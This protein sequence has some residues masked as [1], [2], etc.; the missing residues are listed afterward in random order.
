ML[1]LACV[2]YEHDRDTAS[3]ADGMPALLFIDHA[4]QV[5][6]DIWIF[7]DPGRRLKENGMFP[8]VDAILLL[9]PREDHAYIQN[10][11]TLLRGRLNA[12]I[13]GSP[14]A[15][16]SMIVEPR[17]CESRPAELNMETR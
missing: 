5:R 11:S 4:I 6:H 13:P 10:C 1:F 15:Q 16:P 3:A 2:N 9:I 12:P 8:A 7:E 14:S 17:G